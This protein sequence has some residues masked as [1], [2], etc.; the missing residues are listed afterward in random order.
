ME[1]VL[2]PNGSWTIPF[3]LPRSNEAPNPRR[4]SL[5]AVARDTDRDRRVDGGAD[6]RRTTCCTK[7]FA[8]WCFARSI[9]TPPPPPP[10]NHTHHKTAREIT[11][12]NQDSQPRKT[13]RVRN[14]AVSGEDRRGG[15]PATA[16][17]RSSTHGAEG[18][19]RLSSRSFGDRAFQS[20]PT[21]ATFLGNS[22]NFNICLIRIFPVLWFSGCG[23]GVRFL[24]QHWSSAVCD[25]ATPAFV[26]NTFGGWRCATTLFAGP[27]LVSASFQLYRPICGVLMGVLPIPSPVHPSPEISFTRS[28]PQSQVLLSPVHYPR[29]LWWAPPPWVR[30]PHSA[31]HP[32]PHK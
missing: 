21:F 17:H 23:G 20:G 10:P 18:M 13:R 15:G 2:A 27:G 8:T 11:V 26:G 14:W 16:E 32:Q 3:P 29:T 4:V 5:Q 28:V 24:P 25:S 19:S 31:T 9:T 12:T 30:Y 7:R 22:S 1:M 6:V